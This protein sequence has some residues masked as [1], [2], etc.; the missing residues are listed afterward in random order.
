MG[1]STLSP[2]SND[3]DE[4][5]GFVKS[6]ECLDQSTRSIFSGCSSS[7]FR[8]EEAFWRGSEMSSIT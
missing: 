7:Y 4:S 1:A 6:C 3:D 2:G 5:P 8:T